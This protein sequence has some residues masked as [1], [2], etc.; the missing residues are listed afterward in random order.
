MTPVEEPQASRQSKTQ[1]LEKID[2]SISCYP[3]MPSNAYEGANAI[4]DIQSLSA[5]TT[6]AIPL[7]STSLT[8]PVTAA[9]PS[10][11]QEVSPPT[12]ENRQPEKK[13]KVRCFC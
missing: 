10:G 3:S 4:N 6:I 9:T 8:N 7:P 13:E 12:R 11:A 1:S 2:P 5:E